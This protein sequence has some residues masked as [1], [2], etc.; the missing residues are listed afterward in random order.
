MHEMFFSF[1]VFILQLTVGGSLVYHLNGTLL[2]GP[3]FRLNILSDTV[4]IPSHSATNIRIGMGFNLVFSSPQHKPSTLLLIH[5]NGLCLIPRQ[6]PYKGQFVNRAATRHKTNITIDSSLLVNKLSDPFAGIRTENK[7]RGICRAGDRHYVELAL[8]YDSTFCKMFNYNGKLT[9]AYLQSIVDLSNV[10]FIRD[11]CLELVIV[12]LESHCNPKKDQYSFLKNFPT[13][14]KRGCRAIPFNTPC[15]ASE[16]I[17]FEFSKYWNRYRGHIRRDATVLF[18]GFSDGI[19]TLG[20]AFIGAACHDPPSIQTGYGWIQDGTVETFAHEVGHLL[21]SWHTARGIMSE[22]LAPEFF[23]DRASVRAF[24]KYVDSD[25]IFSNCLAIS[26]PS[27]CSGRCASSC[28]GP[29]KCVPHRVFNLSSP[30]VLCRPVE[31][32]RCVSR[33]LSFLW[34]GEACRRGFD[35]VSNPSSQ[36][37]SLTSCCLQPTGTEPVDI[38]PLERGVSRVGFKAR[39]GEVTIYENYI[40]KPNRKYVK[41]GFLMKTRRVPECYISGGSAHP[42]KTRHS[43]TLDS[44][45]KRRA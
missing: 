45:S 31:T 41:R 30:L 3:F 25:S 15:D 17:L 12:H 29:N 10:A 13:K 34:I 11:T 32:V 5:G 23:F 28:G 26:R 4:P 43:P 37:T 38:Y 14:Y 1:I 40:M 27:S 20:A 35:F 19:G 22:A 18:T 42:R 2:E 24:S 44:S 7:Q 9:D 36:I 16:Y 6:G 33:P 8:V 39:N 21:G